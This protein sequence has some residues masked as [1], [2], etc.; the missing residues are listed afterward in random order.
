VEFL[1]KILA[2]LNPT[3]VSDA[4]AKG[5]NIIYAA[6][7]LFVA[8]KEGWAFIGPLLGITTGV[9]TGQ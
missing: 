5:M 3:N 2:V 7:A 1:K 9:D 4:K 8:L 6:T